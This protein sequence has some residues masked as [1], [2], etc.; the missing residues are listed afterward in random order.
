VARC[1]IAGATAD[2]L[3]GK[4]GTEAVEALRLV[5][6]DPA[7][8]RTLVDGA[9]PIRAEVVHAVRTGMAATVEDV[10]AR[11][12]GLELYDWRLAAQAA[13]CVAALM[14]R[15]LGW[16]AA[17]Q[18]LAADSYEAKI[19]HLLESAGLTPSRVSARSP[20]PRQ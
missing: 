13:P 1:G 8:G 16:S 18:S 10:M 7:L 15:E 19:A 2:H 20:L 11:R 6:T 9:P 17:Q 5:D 12:I 14:G 3:I 4:L